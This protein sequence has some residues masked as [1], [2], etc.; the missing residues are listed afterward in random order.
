MDAFED[1]IYDVVVVEAEE[2]SDDAIALQLAISSGPR[3][4]DLVSITA[5]GLGRSW[6]D[7]LA[8]PATLTVSGGEPK[9]TFD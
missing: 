8:L 1:G 7:L 4:G 3:R 6:M 5:T 2:H 9:L